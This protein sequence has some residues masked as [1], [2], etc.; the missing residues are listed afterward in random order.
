M[1]PPTAPVALMAE[2]S[3]R[4]RRIGDCLPRQKPLRC[5]T[6]SRTLGCPV[7]T[8]HERAPHSYRTSRT[9]GHNSKGGILVRIMLVSSNRASIKRP[10]AARRLGYPAADEGGPCM[11]GEPPGAHQAVGDLLRRHREAAGLSQ[12][13]LALRAGL[14]QQ[15][16]PPLRSALHEPLVT[17]RRALTWMAQASKP[18]SEALSGRLS[19]PAHLDRKGSISLPTGLYAPRAP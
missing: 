4:R 7:P 13:A 3:N 16:G 17:Q 6:A 19:H 10:A 8:G 2:R 12:E 14:V 11:H 15:Q 18:R 9:L 1:K 5:A